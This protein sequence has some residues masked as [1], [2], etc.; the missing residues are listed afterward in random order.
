MEVGPGDC[1]RGG[2]KVGFLRRHGPFRLHGHRKN[3]PGPEMSHLNLQL[4]RLSCSR[5]FSAVHGPE[6]HMKTGVGRSSPA[7]DYLCNT[8]RIT[9]TS[10]TP[11]TRSQG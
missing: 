4:E 11:N 5:G 8:S 6:A 7:P 1:R 10:V 2:S 3:E 9:H